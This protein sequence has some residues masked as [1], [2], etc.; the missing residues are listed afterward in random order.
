MFP[1]SVLS[2]A[3]LVKINWSQDREFEREEGKMM[4]SGQFEYVAE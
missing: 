3:F 2:P 1:G 4:G